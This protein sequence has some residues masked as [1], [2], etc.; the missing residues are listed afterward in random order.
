MW[1]SLSPSTC[2]SAIFTEKVQINCVFFFG[3]VDAQTH[4][5]AHTNDGIEE[6]KVKAE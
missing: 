6:K 5:W 3:S 2:Y 1:K 4:T